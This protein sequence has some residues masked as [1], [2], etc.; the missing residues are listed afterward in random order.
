MA[1][2]KQESVIAE[3]AQATLPKFEIIYTPDE[4]ILALKT[5]EDLP[6]FLNNG[7]LRGL[8]I[9][10]KSRQKWQEFL[11]EDALLVGDTSPEF[12]PKYGRRFQ[13]VIKANPEREKLRITS[14]LGLG[15]HLVISYIPETY[16]LDES[17]TIAA[18]YVGLPEEAFLKLGSGPPLGQA[19]TVGKVIRAA[20]PIIDTGY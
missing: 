20:L 14:N 17:A 2:S 18:S 19:S 5:P 12:D 11:Q 6:G 7:L 10:I 15:L 3:S 1:I 13:A 4:Q 9:G 8:A 16:E